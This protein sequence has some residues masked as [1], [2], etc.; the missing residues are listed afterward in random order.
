MYIDPKNRK[1]ERRDLE[2]GFSMGLRLKE[3]FLGLVVGAGCTLAVNLV[4]D[5][6]SNLASR[7]VQVPYDS[8]IPVVI[9]SVSSADTSLDS[10]H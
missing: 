3:G 10:Y 5:N 4:L 1:S 9:A 7:Q 6:S 8:C 2:S